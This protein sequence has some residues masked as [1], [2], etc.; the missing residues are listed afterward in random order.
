MESKSLY[1]LAIVLTSALVLIGTA[2]ALARGKS[3]SIKESN[4]IAEKFV[5]NSPTYKFDGYDLK[6][7]ETLYPEIVDKPYLWT[8][9]FEFK[10][11]HSGYGDRTGEMV[12]EVIT[13]HE[14]HI[15]VDAGKV[16]TAVLDLKWDMIEQK[17]IETE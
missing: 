4:K 2:Y 8:F 12:N 1:I 16:T 7:I 15:T 5:K 9:V 17:M 10:S 6:H 3:D 11:T 14:A 13:P